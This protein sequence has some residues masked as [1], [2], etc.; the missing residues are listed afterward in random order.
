MKIRGQLEAYPEHRRE[1]FGNLMA[2][3][4]SAS[5]LTQLGKY[6]AAE[7]MYLH[8]LSGY[9]REAIGAKSSLRVIESKSIDFL[10]PIPGEIPT[11]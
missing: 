11:H 2:A 1:D 10:I 4:D 8:T 7:K 6:E 5:V 3:T 9:L